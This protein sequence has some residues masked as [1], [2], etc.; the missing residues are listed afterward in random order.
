MELTHY[1]QKVTIRYTFNGIDTRRFN[2]WLY[3][4]GHS[5]VMARRVGGRNRWHLCDLDAIVSIE[6][7]QK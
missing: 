1:E 2:G 7:Y 6:E 5:H 4:S 3:L